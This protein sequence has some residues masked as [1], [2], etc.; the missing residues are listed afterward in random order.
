MPIP[1]DAAP[2]VTESRVTSVETRLGHIEARQ[3]RAERLLME[4]QGEQRAAFK[5]FHEKLDKLLTLAA[6][7]DLTPVP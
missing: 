7:Q 6:M 5:A 3:V 4:I 1:M 2:M